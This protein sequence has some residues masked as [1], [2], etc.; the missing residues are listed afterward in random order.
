MQEPFTSHFYHR[1]AGDRGRAVGGSTSS[2]H[3]HFCMHCEAC[4]RFTSTNEGSG[5][6]ATLRLP[7]PPPP[8][9]GGTLRTPMLAPQG[10]TNALQNRVGCLRITIIVVDAVIVERIHDS[11]SLLW[12]ALRQTFNAKPFKETD[13][14][15]IACNA[16]C[17]AA[18]LLRQQQNIRVH[19]LYAT[20]T[21]VIL[22]TRTHSFQ[23]VCYFVPYACQ[24]D[25]FNPNPSNSCLLAHKVI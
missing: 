14:T 3:F 10:K 6:S 13:A 24:H 8:N 12:P 20:K 2:L 1:K 17:A 9:G 5:R 16:G 15:S 18:A 19:S 11:S 23:R 21:G 22:E 25:N 4:F 7:P